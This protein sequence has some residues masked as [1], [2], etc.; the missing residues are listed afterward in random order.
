MINAHINP[1]YKSIAKA[2]TLALIL[3]IIIII[4]RLY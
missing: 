1:T 3:I 2:N 4:I